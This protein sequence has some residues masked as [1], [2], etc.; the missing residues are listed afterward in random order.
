MNIKSIVS[1]S[2][3]LVMTSLL[4]FQF[5]YKTNL[6]AGKCI[7]HTSPLFKHLGYFI[8]EVADKPQY[9]VYNVTNGDFLNVTP[10]EMTLTDN[11]KIIKNIQCPKR[12]TIS[13]F[14]IMQMSDIQYKAFQEAIKI[15]LGD[16]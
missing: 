1:L 10:F 3:V 13:L 4:T 8:V 9:M 14:T 6:S 7:Q 15:K 2:C 5:W 12:M 16:E 11:P